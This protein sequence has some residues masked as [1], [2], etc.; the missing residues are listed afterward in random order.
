MLPG[1]I[2]RFLHGRSTYTERLRCDRDPATIQRPHG[3]VETFARSTE[4][5]ISP[6]A[7]VLQLEIHATQTADTERI[8][9]HDTRQTGA[10]EWHDEGRDAA[11]AHALSG[12]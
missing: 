2:E 12:C 8:R 4:Q 9:R 5:R 1:V 7:N 10:V 11:A 6:D 3:D